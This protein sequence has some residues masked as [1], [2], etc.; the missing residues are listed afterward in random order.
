M[1]HLSGLSLDTPVVLI[2][3][4]YLLTLLHDLAD[5]RLVGETVD[6]LEGVPDG[7]ERELG[8]GVAEGDH[9]HLLVALY[10]LLLEAIHLLNDPIVLYVQVSN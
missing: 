1:D 7:G 2:Y 5:Q 4:F 9:T 10:I 8:L 3:L 6:L